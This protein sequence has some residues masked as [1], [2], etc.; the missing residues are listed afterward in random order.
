MLVVVVHGV[1]LL[2]SPCWDLPARA[3]NQQKACP[4]LRPIPSAHRE[5]D[6][7]LHDIIARMHAIMTCI[8]PQ[9]T[10]V[11]FEPSLSDAVCLY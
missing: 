6:G 9:I 7:K 2:Q 8:W 3:L 1:R 11:T 5:V 4:A 10:A